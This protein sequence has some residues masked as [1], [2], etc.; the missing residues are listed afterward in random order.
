MHETQYVVVVLNTLPGRAISLSMK[1]SSAVNAAL[2]SVAMLALNDV[3]L[4]KKLSA[5]RAQQ[6]EKVLSKTLPDLP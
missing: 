3:E 2:F 5:F 6:T 1:A 4:A